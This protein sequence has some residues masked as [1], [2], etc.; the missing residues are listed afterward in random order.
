MDTPGEERRQPFVLD[1]ASLCWVQQS[2]AVALLLAMLAMALTHTAGGSE[3][4]AGGVILVR[5]LASGE[6][7]LYFAVLAAADRDAQCPG[8]ALGLG[9]CG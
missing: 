9:E 6:A 3:R 7:G 2:G 5:T 4:D 8:D 1:V